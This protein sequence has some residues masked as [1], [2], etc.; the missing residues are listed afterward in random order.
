MTSEAVSVTGTLNQQAWHKLVSD[1]ATELWNGELRAVDSGVALDVGHY[2]FLTL[3]DHLTEIDEAAVRSWLSET[4]ERSIE[5]ASS[6]PWRTSAP[7]LGKSSQ[8]LEEFIDRA[9]NAIFLGIEPDHLALVTTAPATASSV[10]RDISAPW[11]SGTKADEFLPTP[12]SVWRGR[13]SFGEYTAD[14]VLLDGSARRLLGTI[15]P[16][17]IRGVRTRGSQRWIDPDAHGRFR[18]EPMP[19]GPSSVEVD[20]PD[21]IFATEWALL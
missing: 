3:A 8:A 20:T 19:P 1:H 14:L 15:S 16:P 4:A 12:D 6:T 13:Y 9:E 5:A 17:R 2:A 21:G 18:I 11:R 7:Y 10:G